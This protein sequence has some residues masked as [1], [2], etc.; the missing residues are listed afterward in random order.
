MHVLRLHKDKFSKTDLEEILQQPV[1]SYDGIYA[2]VR[3]KPNQET[4]NIL[5]EAM[6]SKITVS[7]PEVQ[8][9]EIDMNFEEIKDEVVEKAS[10]V[11]K[12]YGKII[13]IGAGVTGLIA[14]F[15]W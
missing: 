6:R 8:H 1:L 3:E 13:L 7:V 5:R 4:S 2:V 10:S 14:W 11:W 15:L 12:K 9:K